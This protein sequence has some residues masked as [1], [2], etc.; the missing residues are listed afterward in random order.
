MREALASPAWL[1]L[2]TAVL[3]LAGAVELSTQLGNPLLSTDSLA[4]ALDAG[5]SNAAALYRGD[6]V[7]SGFSTLSY[8]ALQF[9]LAAAGARLRVRPD[10][11]SW[12]LLSGNLVAAASWTVVTTQ[13]SYFLVQILWL[14]AGYIAAA[15]GSGDEKVSARAIRWASASAGVLVAF[16]VVARAVR[17]AGSQAALGTE[18]F[19]GGQL[20]AAGYIPAF[21]QWHSGGGGVDVYPWRLLSGV[22]SLSGANVDDGTF[23]DGEN[24]T[25]VGSGQF[26]NAA[27]MMRATVLSAGDA[28]ALLVAIAFG[29]LATLL[30]GRARAGRHQAIAAYAGAVAA[31]LWSVNAWHFTN[32]NRVL[33]QVALQV[34]IAISVVACRGRVSKRASGERTGKPGSSRSTMLNATQEAS[35]SGR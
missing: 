28:G 19:T 20:W 5:K 17:L 15:V 1:L 29:G 26:S 13:R 3:G 11:T 34:A 18:A 22:V 30:Y 32:A 21:S 14:A 31:I 24:F 7:R 25:Y 8:A 27:T 33:A 9:G 2:G 35:T 23:A 6:V 4:S 16:V 12:L 10:R